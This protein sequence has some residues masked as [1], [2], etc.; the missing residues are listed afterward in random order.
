MAEHDF[1]W[2]PD[3]TYAIA[4][5][6]IMPSTKHP[7]NDEEIEV[8]VHISQGEIAQFEQYINRVAVYFDQISLRMSNAA[9]KAT[10]NVLSKPPHG[11]LYCSFD[12]H[13]TLPPGEYWISDFS[14]GTFFD[15]GAAVKEHPD[16]WINSFLIDQNY[17]NEN[18]G[19]DWIALVDEDNVEGYEDA[20]GQ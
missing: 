17:N 4:L 14:A 12:D 7:V 11:L 20:D 16:G 2:L 8:D 5:C 15:T 10:F 18:Y 3:P 9:F 19:R 13:L 6:D 1:E